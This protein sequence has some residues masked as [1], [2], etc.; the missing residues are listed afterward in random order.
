MERAAERQFARKEVLSTS[1]RHEADLQSNMTVPHL[2]FD[3]GAGHKGRGCSERQAPVAH[4]C[5]DR[6]AR[7]IV[8]A[9]AAT[10][11]GV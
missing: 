6:R 11:G 10:G 5:R 7:A 9:N 2:T 4:R 3:L 8:P 1:L